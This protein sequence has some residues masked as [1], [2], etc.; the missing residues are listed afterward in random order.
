MLASFWNGL[1]NI[2]SR[3]YAMLLIGCGV[4]LVFSGQKDLGTSLVL[5]GA[6]VFQHPQSQLVK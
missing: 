5:L 6:A 4:A 2:D 3:L 1:N